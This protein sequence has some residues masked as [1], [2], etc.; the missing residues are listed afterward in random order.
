MAASIAQNK[1]PAPTSPRLTGG[2]KQPDQQAA[3]LQAAGCG[4]MMIDRN[5][6]RGC[7]D[8]HNGGEKTR[9]EAATIV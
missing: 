4:A 6:G 1:L 3:G 7:K 8:G 9:R 2:C 5:E